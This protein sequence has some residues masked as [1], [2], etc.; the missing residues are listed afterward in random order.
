MERSLSASIFFCS[1]ISVITFFV[2]CKARERS[3]DKG[4]SSDVLMLNS[5]EARH[6]YEERVIK[7]KSILKMINYTLE[8]IGIE[9]VLDDGMAG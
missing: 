9:L 6:E 2:A 4:M 8:L 7:K 3:C 1:V 5:V